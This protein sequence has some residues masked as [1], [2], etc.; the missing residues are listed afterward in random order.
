MKYEIVEKTEPKL[1]FKKIT[2]KHIN[3]DFIFYVYQ[4]SKMYF[5]V[6]DDNSGK[7]GF[8]FAG[9][10]LHALHRNH[11]NMLGY[12]APTKEESIV[13]AIRNNLKIYATDSFAEA[14]EMYI[15]IKNAWMIK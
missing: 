1:E 15:E 2:V 7:W 13:R 4:F 8:V 10:K 9:S 6:H 14:C 12:Q 3:S 5:L 11:S